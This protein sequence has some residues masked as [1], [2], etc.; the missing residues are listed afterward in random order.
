MSQP[1]EKEWTAGIVS[2]SSFCV[3]DRITN[4]SSP[5]NTSIQRYWYVV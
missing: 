1:K 2:L 4:Y 3:C 5:E